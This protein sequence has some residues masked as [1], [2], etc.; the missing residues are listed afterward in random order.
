MPLIRANGITKLF[1]VKPSFFS[2]TKYLRAVDKVSIHINEGETVGLVGESG[3]GKTTLGKI[4]TNLSRPNSGEVFIDKINITSLRGKNLRE[5]RK[6]YQMIFQD[7]YTSLNPRK[8][9]YSIIDE[10]LFLHTRLNKEERLLKT[11]ELL[12]MVGLD[13]KHLRRYPH[14][15]SGGQRQ[16]IGIARALAV[17][18]DFIVADE[19]VSALDVSVQAQIINLL[20]TIQKRT[21]VAFLF[22]SHDLAVVEHI[23]KRI[24]VM[25]LGKVVES[26][27]S[28]KICSNPEHPYTQALL[29][30]VPLPERNKRKRARLK[31]DIPSPIN[32]PSG[33]SFHTRCPIAIEKC[34]KEIPELKST[35]QDK[36]HFVA[37]FQRSK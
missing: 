1:P 21:N 28:R 27:M 23:C 32:P 31:G 22:I 5:S 30:S 14:Q 4:L 26:G 17:N 33:C 34:R 7:P 20:F 35:N 18:P 2:K 8:N 25:Y 12:S 15:F 24:I 9:I 13:R 16:R 3:C 6:K 37:C 36:N 10:T 11:E 29:E 19:P